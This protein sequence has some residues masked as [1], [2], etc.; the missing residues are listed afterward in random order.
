MRFRHAAALTLLAATAVGLLLTRDHWLPVPRA[1]GPLPHS[2]YVWQRQADAPLR[3]ALREHAGAFAHVNRLAAEV[4]WTP[5]GPQVARAALPVDELR[6]LASL[7]LTLRLGSLPGEI[8]GQPDDP[9]IPYLQNLAADLL[10]EALGHGLPVTELHIDF[11]AAE[12][13]LFGYA[14]WLRA[15]RPTLPADIRLTLTALPAWLDQRAGFA[16]LLEATDAYVL[17]IHSLERPRADNPDFMLYRTDAARRAVERAA[18]FGKPF[19]VSLPTYGYPLLFDHAANT[20]RIALGNLPAELPPGL[21]LRTVHTSPADMLDLLQGWTTDRP[22][23]LAG[24]IWFRLPVADDDLNWSWPTLAT[25]M[26]GQLPAPALSLHIDR[27]RAP[28]IAL[29]LRNTGTDTFAGPVNIRLD[30]LHDLLASDTQHPFL[31]DTNGSCATPFLRLAPD[32]TVPVAWLRF[33]TPTPD[34]HASL[35]T[36]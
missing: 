31:A 9:R 35:E 15:L 34:F 32:R 6:P 8:I 29:H 4:G 1:S 17:Q 10:A 20:S 12:S 16:A 21:S 19:V 23:A 5:D 27:S 33:T 26:T 2:V 13:Q 3:T 24:I 28:L 36:P 14:N 30:H 25:V 18:R 22:A 11:D 7:G